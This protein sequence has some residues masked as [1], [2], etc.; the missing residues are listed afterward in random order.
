MSVHRRSGTTVEFNLGSHSFFAKSF[1]VFIFPL[2]G[3]KTPNLHNEQNALSHSKSNSSSSSMSRRSQNVKH[4]TWMAKLEWRS[5]L[6]DGGCWWCVVR[7]DGRKMCV[8][9]RF[10][11]G[12]V[13]ERWVGGGRLNEVS[14]SLRLADVTAYL[15]DRSIVPFIVFHRTSHRR[16]CVPHIVCFFTFD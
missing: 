4:L 12:G 3:V 5:E 15:T 1:C 8:C 10:S 13:M 11:Y 7:H 6:G 16:C 14:F 9:G 2:T